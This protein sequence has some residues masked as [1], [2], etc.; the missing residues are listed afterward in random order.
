MM[1]PG[2]FAA[3]CKNLG[4][5]PDFGKGPHIA[6]VLKAE[7]P[8]AREIRSPDPCGGPYFIGGLSG[9]W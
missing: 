9:G 1:T 6:K 3:S 5:G 4:I 7:A 2:Q 8:H